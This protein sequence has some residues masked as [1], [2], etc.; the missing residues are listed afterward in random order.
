MLR[1]NPITSFLLRVAV[2]FA[3]LAAPWPGVKEAYGTY[4]R[5]VCRMVF[6]AENEKRELSFETAGENSSR[7]NDT[8]VVI[9]NKALMQPDGSGAV[10]NLDVDFGWQSTAVLVALIVATPLPWRRRG[11]ALL[12]GC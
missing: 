7:P 5:A 12:W 3:L 9:V 10:R 1:R 2:A 8:R 4:F 6:P 11:W